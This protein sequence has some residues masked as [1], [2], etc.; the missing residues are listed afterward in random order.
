[1][2]RWALFALALPLMGCKT[3]PG[4]GSLAEFE[5]SVVF[6]PL[7]YDEE[8]RLYDITKYEDAWFTA[9]DGTR[10]HGWYAAAEK[11]RAV[12]LYCHGNAGNIFG[13]ET[14]MQFYRDYLK[15]S[16][17]MFDYRGY[18]KS[19]GEPSEEGVLADARAARSWLAQR[20]KV[21]ES[22]I[23]LVGN[24]LGGGVAVDLAAKDGARALVLENTFTSLPDVAARHFKMLPVRWLMHMRLDSA[25]NIA[26]YHG[27]LLQTHGT[28]DEV[29]P[30]DL[31]TRLFRLANEP[32]RFIAVKDG[33][34]KDPLTKEYVAA[35]EEFIGGL[36]GK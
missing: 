19:D 26:S 4:S 23:V 35:L 15:C 7:P 29:I 14:V 31:G 22:E 20:A 25:A 13:R 28:A 3:L 21:I 11:P 16:I 5:R 18:G 6:Q 34:H 10:L 30:Y 24:S 8:E 36:S 27:P 9:P 17:L 1:M 2:K 32:K 33:R 12:V